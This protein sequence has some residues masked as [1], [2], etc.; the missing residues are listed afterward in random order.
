MENVLKHVQK[1][2][3]H[4]RM[5][6]SEKHSK[7]FTKRVEEANGGNIPNVQHVYVPCRNIRSTAKMENCKLQQCPRILSVHCRSCITH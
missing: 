2:S 3:E 1:W 7:M 6:G 5:E 4:V